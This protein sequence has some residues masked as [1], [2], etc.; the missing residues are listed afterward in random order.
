[1]VIERSEFH[2]QD[3]KA[4]EVAA[5]IRSRGLA[6][7]AQFT[8]CTSFQAYQCVEKPNSIMVLAEWASIDAH[9]ESRSEPVHVAFREM[10]LPYAAGA[11]PTVHFIEIRA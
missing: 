1:V 3:G 4:D 10:L 2:L 8:G 6:L 7:G 9:L 11:E 5:L